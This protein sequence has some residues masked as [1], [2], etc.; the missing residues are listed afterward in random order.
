M[1]NTIFFMFP[2]SPSIAQFIGQ[3]GFWLSVLVI[4]VFILAVKFRKLDEDPLSD[5]EKKKPDPWHRSHI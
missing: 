2:T 3:Y 4:I 1:T 5:L